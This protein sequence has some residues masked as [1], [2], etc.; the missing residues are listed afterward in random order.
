MGER[1][2]ARVL[3]YL[4]LGKVWVEL[5]ALSA[6]MRR[7]EQDMSGRRPTPLPPVRPMTIPASPP[8]PPSPIADAPY[9]SA[10]DTGVR[11]REV[12]DDPTLRFGRNRQNR[13]QS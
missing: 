10:A 8:P 6:R 12:S 11:D 2:R 4:G 13:G 3:L 9:E 1:L 7:I 5:E